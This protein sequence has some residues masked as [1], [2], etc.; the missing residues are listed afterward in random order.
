MVSGAWRRPV[1]QLSTRKSISR[2][3]KWMGGPFWLKAAHRKTRTTGSCL[4][5]I[6][7]STRLYSTDVRGACFRGTCKNNRIAQIPESADIWLPCLVRLA[8]IESALL[9]LLA[10]FLR[11]SANI[12]SPSLEELAIL[13]NLH[14]NGSFL[15]RNGSFRSICGLAAFCKSKQ[16]L[17]WYLCSR[18]LLRKSAN[19]A[20][21][22]KAC[23]TG[24]IP[25]KSSTSGSD[26]G[27]SRRRRLG[28]RAR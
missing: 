25:G 13:P 1:S 2:Y 12:A 14:R 28:S 3:A 21:P 8:K 6:E 17:Q 22:S 7:N 9:D 4:R 23:P 15:H 27:P 11:R 5:V 16:T 19:I 18:R 26:R 24:T 10:G 20:S